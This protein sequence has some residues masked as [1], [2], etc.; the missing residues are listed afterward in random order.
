[1]QGQRPWSWVKITLTAL[2]VGAVA[3]VVYQATH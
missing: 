1:V 3:F 2:V